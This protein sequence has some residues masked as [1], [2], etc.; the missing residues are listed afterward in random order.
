LLKNLSSCICFCTCE[1]QKRGVEQGPVPQNLDIYKANELNIATPVNINGSYPFP[2]DTLSEC[3][4]FIS[5][6]SL[7][8]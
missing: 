6:L 7:L 5:N 4:T 1:E 8:I 2:Y 3:L